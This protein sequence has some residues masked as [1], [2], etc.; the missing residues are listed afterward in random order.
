MKILLAKPRGF[1]AGVKRAINI[2]ERVLEIYGAPIFV[3]HEI[4][5]N[6]YVINNLQNRGVIFVNK[7]DNVPEK[8]ILIFSAHGVSRIIRQQAIK[9]NL[10]MLFDATCPLVT[11]VHLEVVRASRTGTEAILIGHSGHPEIEGTM[12]QYHNPLGGIYLIE[13]SEDIY[14]LQVKNENKLCVMTQTTLSIN[15]SKK[16]INKLRSHFPKIANSPHKD[17]CYATTNR[18]TAV[19]NLAYKTDLVLVVGSK[20]S[21]N[22]NRLVEQAKSIGTV[23]Y[24]ID[25]KEDIDEKWIKNISCIGVTAGASAPDIL[26][27]QVI[28]RL[29]ELGGVNVTELV[30]CE[31]KMIFK[32][33]KEL[34]I[35]MQILK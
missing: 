18:Q 15:D 6:R 5:H 23:S 7:I 4:V 33:P 2:V 30:G 25:S 16:I 20:N 8:S 35:A 9:R 14:K 34:H 12:G 29:S 11:K 3:Y 13:K 27:Q 19:R 28:E 1:C 26:V 24:L 32:I 17:I 10:T 22:S 31:E 21:S